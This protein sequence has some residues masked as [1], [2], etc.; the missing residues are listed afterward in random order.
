MS[1]Q[2]PIGINILTAL[3]SKFEADRNVSVA[4]LS[5]Y[6]NNPVGVGE[7][8]DLANEVEALIDKIAN[9]EEKLKVVQRLLSPP[10]AQKTDEK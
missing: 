7:H 6:I 5:I 2:N 10:E 8:P 3:A 1:L 4:N 9:A